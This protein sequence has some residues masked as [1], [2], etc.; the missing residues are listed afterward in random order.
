MATYIKPNAIKDASIE[1]IKIKDGTISSSKIDGTVA[2]KSYVDTQITEVGEAMGATQEAFLSAYEE[3][4]TEINSLTE[5]TTALEARATNAVKVTYT[6]LKSL[7]DAGKLVAGTQYRI[8]D[9]TCTTTQKNT[10]SAGHQF[11]IIV[12]ADDENTLNE[13]A[14]ACCSDFDI[15]KYKD[16][17]SPTWSEKMTY[18]GLYQYEGKEYHLYESASQDM[19]MLVDFKTITFDVD[20]TSGNDQKEVYPF[21]FRPTFAKSDEDWDTGEN[22]GEIIAFKNYPDYFANSDLSAWQIWYCLD[23][24]TTRFAWADATNGK[25]VIYRMIDEWNNDVPYDFKNIQFARDWSVVAPDSGLAGI[26]YCYTF[27]VF[28]DGFI[29]NATADDES[30]K[31]KECIESDEE[32]VFGNNV[33]RT[34]QNLGV[35]FLNGIVF[36][37]D[38]ISFSVNHHSNTFGNNCSRNTLGNDCYCNTFGNYCSRN[39]FGNECYYNTFGNSCYSNT[40]GN[41]CWNINFAS[42]KTSTTK[43]NYYQHNHFGD[44]CQYILFKGTET[45]SISQQVQNYNFAQGLQGTSSAYLT[46]DG[47]RGRSFE[48]YISKDTDGTVKESVIAEKLDK[49]IEISYNDLVTLR[50]SSKLVPG[51]QYRIT[52]YTCTTTQEGTQ[53]AGHQ[54]DIIV[55]ADDESTL[56]EVARA[57]LHTGDEYFS[58][59]NLNAWKLWY[60]LDNDINRFAWAMMKGKY[61][62]IT[63][64]EATMSVRYAETK[65]I[66]DIM[67]E[68]WSTPEPG[69]YVGTKTLEVGEYCDAISIDEGGSFIVDAENF[70]RISDIKEVEDGKGVIYRMIDEFNND[71]PYDFKNIQF[72]RKW[73]ETKQLWS[74]ISYSTAGVPCYT[75]SSE[76]DSSTTEFTD[77]S[78]IRDGQVYSNII[79]VGIRGLN[80]SC[81]FGNNCY[82]NTFGNGCDYNTFG[83]N[84]YNNTFG[85]ECYSNTF[86]NSFQANT[87]GDNCGSNTFGNSCGSNTFG[88]DCDSNTFGNYIQKSQFGDGVQYFS[89]TT[90]QMTTYPTSS[91]LKNYIR[92]LIVENGVRYVNAYVTGSTSSSSQCQNVRI[93]LG[94]QGVHPDDRKTF[95]ITSCINSKLNNVYQPENSQTTSV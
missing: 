27:S 12:T 8:T 33:I 18:I 9:Y 55:T 23:N 14:R 60:S 37:T 50:G 16:A 20:G 71:V 26:I 21:A 91:Y 87:F 2:S 61:I 45:T 79:K 67:Y 28:L 59:C 69:F 77:M 1:G 82:K 19:Q 6:E 32:G 15:E 44:G 90:Q 62:D 76:G 83:N 63:V 95:D 92:W 5:K 68:L 70:A 17:Y 38:W 84:C 40:F 11:D 54:F 85:N 22:F 74:T 51:Q 4:G 10:K 75:F 53:S 73:D 46:I 31:A 35:C 78:L 94:I 80:N 52:D 30:V 72:Y 48:T 36:V 3:L 29:E 7:R 39:T 13:V 86:G 41:N 42:D 58:G 43:Y 65:V 47:V 64:E 57:A 93:C 49:I 24:D 56:N 66:N 81:F 25:G 34:N 89:I 88:N